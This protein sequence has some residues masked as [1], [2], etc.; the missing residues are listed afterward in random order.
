MEL[1]RPPAV[2]GRN[3]ADALRSGLLWGYAGQ[4]DALVGRIRQELGQ[5]A[6]VVA[7]GGLASFIRSFSETIDLVDSQLT[8]DGLRMIWQRNQGRL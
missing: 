6:R 5:E 1:R 2:I 7:T 3:T 4:T 8:L